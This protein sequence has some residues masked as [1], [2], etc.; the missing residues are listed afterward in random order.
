[1]FIL[2]HAITE[3]VKEFLQGFQ[4]NKNALALAGVSYS[5]SSGCQGTCWGSCADGCL[6]GCQSGCYGGAKY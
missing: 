4:T 3:K 1:M 5:N 2:N 6:G